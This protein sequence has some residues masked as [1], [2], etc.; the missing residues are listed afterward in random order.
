M[1]AQSC[2]TSMALWTALVS[3]RSELLPAVAERGSPDAP[4]PVHTPI[5]RPDSLQ[6]TESPM[7]ITAASSVETFPFRP[8][9]PLQPDTGSSTTAS[10]RG[11]WWPFSRRRRAPVTP[12][13]HDLRLRDEPTPRLSRET[14]SSEWTIVESGGPSAAYPAFMPFE[15]G[16][17]IEVVAAPRPRLIPPKRVLKVS[18]TRQTETISDP[19]LPSDA[20]GRSVRFAAQPSPSASGVGVAL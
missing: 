3:P 12:L 2:A 14:V 16:R 9:L 18:T 1:T 11:R 5:V 13:S 10:A 7:A 8:S 19:Q 6:R 15:H 4:L 17:T 20:N